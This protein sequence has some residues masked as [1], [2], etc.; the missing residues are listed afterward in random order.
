MVTT[1]DGRYSPWIASKMVLQ[2]PQTPRFIGSTK[3]LTTKHIPDHDKVSVTHQYKS[4]ETDF[5]EFKIK[6]GNDENIEYTT[7]V[8]PSCEN[9]YEEFQQ[10]CFSKEFNDYE[11]NLNMTT[12]MEY[13]VSVRCSNYI[14][15]SEVKIINIVL[16]I[17]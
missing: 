4:Q 1:E 3:I 11:I 6:N 15:V 16:I 10:K 14:C 5:C 8:P 2:R 9:R 12:C 13:N 7:L 17:S